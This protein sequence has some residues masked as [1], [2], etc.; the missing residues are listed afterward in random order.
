MS[1]NIKIEEGSGNIFKDLGFSDEV[2]EKELLKA[3]LGAEI[4][5][6]LKER[7]LN[8]VEAAKLLGVEHTEISRLE[9]AKLSDY[10][11][12]R[13]M[14]FLNQLN[15]DIEIRIIPSEDREGQQRVVAV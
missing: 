7:K 12:E 9:A 13:L 6:I 8:Q 2:S 5:R 14:R 1:S 4:F 11:V 15:R 10:S 3:Q